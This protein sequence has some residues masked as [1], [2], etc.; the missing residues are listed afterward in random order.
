MKKSTG[1]ILFALISSSCVKIDAINI[2]DNQLQATAN[3]DA[4]ANIT[5]NT[6]ASANLQSNLIYNYSAYPVSINLPEE[7]S[8][9]EG[10]IL[11]IGFDPKFDLKNIINWY[12]SNENILKILSPGKALGLLEGE[13]NIIL[14]HRD[15]KAQILKVKVKKS[16]TSTISSPSVVILPSHTP[17]STPSSDIIYTIPSP[18]SYPTIAPTPYPTSTVTP[19]YIPSPISTPT[20]VPVIV[21][22]TPIVPTP[23]IT[24]TPFVP[25]T[26]PYYIT[27]PLPNTKKL[28]LLNPNGGTFGL[29]LT[30]KSMKF[31]SDGK[32]IVYTD[33]NGFINTMNYDGTEKIKF[34]N[35]G[36]FPQFTDN[37]SKILY[38]ND[39]GIFKISLDGINK[40]L[41]SKSGFGAVVKFSP[42]GK[43]LI[44]IN[45]SSYYVMYIDGSEKTKLIPIFGLG[46]FHSCEWSDDSSK[47]VINNGENGG[48]LVDK[49]IYIF[50]SNGTNIKKLSN[51]GFYPALSPDNKKIAYYTNEGLFI[52][53]TDGTEKVQLTNEP[54]SLLGLK[55]DWSSDSSKIAYQ[56]YSS[57]DGRAT[58]NNY[59]INVFD[60]ETMSSKNISSNSFLIEWNDALDKIIVYAR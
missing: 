53:N 40:E 3:V 52:I 36:Y 6:N 11:D 28:N 46:F 37:N 55:I 2:K 35:I 59:F 42:D 30:A 17:T 10:S 21:T 16:N 58:G 54:N 49:V 26:K 43:K 47:I 50:E 15:Q 57:I 32:K 19:S 38:F 14:L 27:A 8:I 31:S 12:S 4:K 20:P 39:E 56:I 60:F 13:A 18:T 51:T 5:A 23:T 24:P 22:P 1:F 9:T 45:D 44:Y 33:E 48:P 7:I 41:I 34:K 29:S 25:V